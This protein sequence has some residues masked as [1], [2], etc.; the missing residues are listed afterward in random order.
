[1]KSKN[2]KRRVAGLFISALIVGAPALAQLSLNVRDADVRAFIQDAAKATGRTFIID[3]RVQGK[4][5][6]VTDRPLSKSEYFEIFLSTLR[7]NGLVAV[8]APGGSFRIQPADGAASQPSPVGRAANRNQFVTEVIRLRAI[9]P[10]S[11]MDTIRPLVSKDGTVSANRSGRS[12]VV[13]DYADNIARIRQIIA[14]IDTDA[15]TTTVVALSNA[16]AREI[17]GSL[18]TLLTGGAEGSQPSATVVAVDSSNSIAIRGDSVTVA[19]LVAM[20]QD[21]DKRAAAGTEVRVYWLDHADADKLMPVLQ[22]LLGQG[23]ITSGG[24]SGSSSTPTTGT[25]RGGAAPAATPTPVVSS[26]PS[27]GAG[28]ATRGPA[29]VTRY[30]GTNALIVAANADVQRQ[31]GEVIRQL[32]TRRPQVMI[33]AII[34]EIGDDAAKR[35]G[36]QFLI[37]S[38]KVGFAGTNYSN[39]QPSILTLAGAIA[40]TKLNERTTTVINPNG[41]TTTTTETENTELANE[42]QKGAVS[43]LQNATGGFGGVAT[44]LGKNGIFGAILSAVQSDTKSSILSTPSITTLDNMKAHMLVGQEIPITT[45]QALSNNFD[46]Q[47]RTVQ[48]ENVGIILDVTPQVSGNGQVKLFIKQEVSSIAGP[49]SSNNSDLILNK[50]EFETTVLVDD[51]EIYAIGGLLD[52]NERR[53]IEK[54]PLLSDIPVIGELFKSRSKSRTKTNLVVFIRPTIL[55]TREDN[56]EVTARRYGYVRSVQ[57]AV[58]PKE[59]PSID[60]LVRDYMGAALPVTDGPHTGDQVIDGAAAAT[61]APLPAGAPKK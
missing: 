46:N 30:E 47:F 29:V 56:A 11:A 17:A 8:P 7:A 33:E 5:S 37:G 41:S 23:A 16:G 34:V 4:V 58:N 36:V 39:A 25:A 14:R 13:A 38:T 32:D 54:L 61:T 21:L 35:L 9:D 53:T 48:R 52:E 24:S 10:Q 44:Q 43:A 22:Q 49:V 50:R 15:N 3:S 19:K 28:I 40:A 51:G 57:K 42:L 55:Q 20:A 45:G 1:M 12:I 2:F 59:E 31:V 27:T 18:Q 6:V 26:A 60:A